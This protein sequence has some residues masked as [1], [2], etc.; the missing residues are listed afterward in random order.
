MQR[1]RQSIVWAVVL[2]GLLGLFAFPTAA[3]EKRSP[4]ALPSGRGISGGNFVA[5]NDFLDINVGPQG[6]D[7]WAFQFA[8]NQ[9][10]DAVFSEHFPV[11]TPQ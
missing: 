4:Y 10:G 2:V 3:Q 1:C 8:P 9:W 11:W 6:S 5:R 7:Y